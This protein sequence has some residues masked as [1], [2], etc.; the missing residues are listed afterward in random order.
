MLHN[1]VGV[2]PRD[3][4]WGIPQAAPLLLQPLMLRWTVKKAETP[5]DSKTVGGPEGK[6]HSALLGPPREEEVS[7]LDGG[8]SWENSYRASVLEPQCFKALRARSHLEPRCPPSLPCWADWAMP[9]LG[10]MWDSGVSA[11]LC[12]SEHYVFP[13]SLP[14][15]SFLSPGAAP[16]QPQ[17][18]TWPH[19]LS[20]GHRRGAG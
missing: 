16:P 5:G 20:E 17:R 7:G 3:T 10:G 1:L 6:A 9:V 12:R 13:I 14:Q 8:E 4:G 18:L 11:G 15:S 2:R 19:S